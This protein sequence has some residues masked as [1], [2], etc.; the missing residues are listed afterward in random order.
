MLGAQARE[1]LWVGAPQEGVLPAKL[2]GSLLRH[3]VG[4][5]AARQRA[6]GQQPGKALDCAVWVVHRDV[7][8]R[9][10]LADGMRGRRRKHPGGEHTS[11]GQRQACR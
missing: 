4:A 11:H 7:H 8:P 1:D 5:L 10:R 2:G 6:V 9:K 3:V